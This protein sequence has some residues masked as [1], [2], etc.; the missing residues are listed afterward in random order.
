MC[1]LLW[2]CSFFVVFSPSSSVLYLAF[3][4][5]TNTAR[6]PVLSLLWYARLDWIRSQKGK[7]CHHAL[8]LVK[9]LYFSK[10]LFGFAFAVSSLMD[11]PVTPVICLKVISQITRVMVYSSC[12]DRQVIRLVIFESPL[13][14]I[15]FWR[16][17]LDQ[18]F[19]HFCDMLA[20][21][22]SDHRKERRVVLH[23]A[24]KCCLALVLLTRDV[25]C[26]INSPVVSVI[27]RTI[28]E[29]DHRKE[30]SII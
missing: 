1:C 30:R 29:S 22:E 28:I 5:A 4:I 14:E 11:N 9:W 16:R 23:F 24:G 2:L 17:L 8:I 3:F 7:K 20:I 12:K 10:Q 26:L 25:I 18:R 19:C 21:I 27:C 13:H 15:L 6:W